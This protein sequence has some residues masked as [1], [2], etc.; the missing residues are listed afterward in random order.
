MDEARGMEPPGDVTAREEVGGLDTPVLPPRGHLGV[1][2]SSVGSPDALADEQFMRL[3]LVSG[4]AASAA[5]DMPVGAVAVRNGEVIARTFNMKEATGDPTA[6]AEMLALRD[7]SRA[8]GRWRLPD[9]TLYC[10]L[11]PC[12]MCAGAMVLA[13]I[14]RL[15]FA[16]RD[17]R[18]GAAG[19]VFDV[20][21][22]PTLNH[23]VSVTQGVL[24]DESAERLRE[25][26]RALRSRKRRG[27]Q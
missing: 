16:T 9:V 8:L 24:A 13:R 15:V 26:A 27:S 10:T 1:P 11:E 14:G 7:A 22:H 5:G 2:F 18:T 17:P 23:R 6:H 20:L 21:E 4:E 19:S 3:A 12:M 25:F